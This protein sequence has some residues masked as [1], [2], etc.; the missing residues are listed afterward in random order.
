MSVDA[1]DIRVVEPGTKVTTRIRDLIRYHELIV[2]LVRKELRVKY[3]NS[4]LGFVWSMLN[5]AMTIAIFWI[6]FTKFLGNSIPTYP[7]WILS[8]ILAWNLWQ[9]SL[10]MS[11]A[12]FLGNSSLVTKVY[13]PREALPLASIGANLMH[14][15]F[16]FFVLLAALVI[17]RFPISLATLVLVPTALLTELLVL[18]G[19]CLIVAVMNVYFRDVQHLLELTLLAWFWMTPI[20]YQVAFP[21]QHLGKISTI[22]PKIYMLNPMTSIV[23]AFQRGIYQHISYLDRSTTPP[24]HVQLLFHQGILWYLRNLGIV[25][26]AAVVMIAIGWAIFRRLEWRLAEEL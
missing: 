11:V 17:F 12:S 4:V 10:G 24:T 2:N 16:Q 7:I 8:G 3:K 19:F 25:A 20:V 15:F 13:F 22:L 21:I 26:V 5:P 1:A 23:L 14:F 6:V 9:G 18:C